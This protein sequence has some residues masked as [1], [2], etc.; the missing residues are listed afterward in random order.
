MIKNHVKMGWRNLRRSKVY[1]FINIVRL[2]FGI[3]CF[4]L[5]G[6]CVF[7]EFSFDRRGLR[8]LPTTSM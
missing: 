4:L 2:T 7:D 6:L 5:I 3:T 1:S 8:S